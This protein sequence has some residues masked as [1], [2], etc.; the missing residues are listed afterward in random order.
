L[1]RAEDNAGEIEAEHRPAGVVVAGAA[2]DLPAEGVFAAG[3]RRRD[4]IGG[5]EHRLGGNGVLAAPAPRGRRG[6]VVVD[7][8]VGAGDEE[9]QALPLNV[10]A[11]HRPGSDVAAAGELPSA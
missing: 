5:A 11:E 8:P 3:E 1:G 10:A 2:V 4:A 6:P 9:V 7:L